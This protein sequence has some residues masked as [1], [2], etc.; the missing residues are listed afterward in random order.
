MGGGSPW[1]LSQGSCCQCHQS[2]QPGGHQHTLSLQWCLGVLP[3]LLP[4]LIPLLAGKT[5]MKNL[6]KHISCGD[7]PAGRQSI[8]LGATSHWSLHPSRFLQHPTIPSSQPPPVGLM[9]HDSKH[10]I[11]LWGAKRGCL[12]QRA[13]NQPPCWE[14]LVSP[15]PY[16][17]CAPCRTPRL[18]VCY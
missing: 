10:K 11:R 15:L 9:E 8:P 6:I 5:L 7:R 17:P 16:F 3:S 2:H 18:D 4:A 1:G 13:M 14:L 12:Q